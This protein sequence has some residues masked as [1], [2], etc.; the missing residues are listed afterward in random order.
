[1]FYDTIY[2]ICNE[3]G[4]TPTTVLRELGYSSGNVSKWKK[5]SVPNIDIAYKIAQHLGVSVDYLITGEKEVSSKEMVSGL[6]PEWAEIISA[7]PEENQE[8]C[9]D[10]LR[11]H[12]AIPEK[13]ADRKKG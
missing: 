12:M 11:T 10:F 5:G 6:D 2:K 3:K 4:T 7:I 13:Y 9:K 1:M 8:M